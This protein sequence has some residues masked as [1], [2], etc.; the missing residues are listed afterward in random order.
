MNLN[1]FNF[2]LPDDLIALR[3]A[4]PRQA[5]RLL[6]VD[7]DGQVTDKTIAD[8]TTLL[9]AGDVL[10]TN[11]SRVVPAA[12][13]GVRA[14][15]D[16]RGNDVDVEV[17]LIKRIAPNAW[18]ALAKPARRLRVGDPITI[19]DGFVARVDRKG[20]DGTIDLIFDQSG[21]ALD[22]ALDAHGFMPLPPYIAN[23]RKADTQDRDDYQTIFADDTGS[24]AAPTAGLHFTPDLMG[25]LKNMG[26][27]HHHVTLHVGAGTFLPVKVD[28]VDDHKMHHEWGQVS[29]ATAAAIAEAKAD[30]RRVVVVGTTALRILESAALATGGIQSFSGDT[31]IFIK[32]GFEFKVADVLLT[33]FHLPK[34]TLFMLV[35]AFAGTN[36]M[37]AAYAHAIGQQYRFFS[38]GDAC[39]LECGQ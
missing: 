17:N 38:Y 37:K 23:K 4:V 3:P 27:H 14:K 20:T 25:Q 13:R 22:Q 33:N 35:C 39:L 28:N 8:I 26:V 12:L 7:G 34:S 31:D 16:F 9:R 19:A 24:V 6:H 10:I 29:D 11:N 32:P 5:A 2:D 18:Q 1:D 30:K 36:Q 15:R 21:D